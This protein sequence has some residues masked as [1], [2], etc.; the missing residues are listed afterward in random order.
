[1]GKGQRERGTCEWKVKRG[2][3]MKHWKRWRLEIRESK[4]WEGPQIFRNGLEHRRRGD[5]RRCPFPSTYK[6]KLFPAIRFHFSYPHF[7]ISLLLFIYFHFLINLFIL[8]L[9]PHLAFFSLDSCGERISIY[10]HS[11]THH[12]PQ[13][14]QLFF[15]I[16]C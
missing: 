8:C 1:M 9:D 12:A 13:F 6:D 10:F 3:K 11:Y 2:R 5:R 16:Y 7:R 15:L 14:Y 4:K